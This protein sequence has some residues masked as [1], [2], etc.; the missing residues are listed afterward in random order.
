[1]VVSASGSGRAVRPTRGAT[2]EMAE[3]RIPEL[4]VEDFCSLRQVTLPL[5]PVN[6]LVGP[7]GA[8]K[9]NV[10]EAFQFLSATGRSGLKPSGALVWWRGFARSEDESR[11]PGT[12]S[13]GGIF[14]GSLPV[15]PK[16]GDF[17][18]DRNRLVCLERDISSHVNLRALSAG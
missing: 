1:M 5:G 7:N 3:Q 14:P 17:A 8:G 16:S 13:S 12:P 2:E 10:L 6:V 9:T 15:A 11:G 4:W 18:T